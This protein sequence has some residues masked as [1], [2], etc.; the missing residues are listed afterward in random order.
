MDGRQP[1]VLLGVL[2]LA[3]SVGLGP[4]AA[5]GEEPD[6][7]RDGDTVE[8]DDDDSAENG[9]EIPEFD[10]EEVLVVTATRTERDVLDISQPVAVVNTSAIRETMAIGISDVIHKVPGVSTTNLGGV[11]YW[12]PVIRGLSG[13]RVVMLLD[14]TR[15][16]T[17]RTMGVTGFF[18]D[19][20]QVKRVEVVRG[21]SSVL[22]GTDAIGGVINVLTVDPFED[23]GLHGRLSTSVGHNN[24]EASGGLGVGYTSK[25]LTLGLNGRLRD[26]GNYVDGNGDEILMSHYSDRMFGGHLG[27]RPHED[28]RIMIRSQNVM[29]QDV[30]KAETE[31][32]REKHRWIHFPKDDIHRVSAAWDG[33]RLGR[34]VHAVHLSG[35]G[36]WNLRHNEINSFTSDYETLVMRMDKKTRVFDF[37]ANAHVVLDLHP[38]NRLTVG[39]EATHKTM[40]M[41]MQPIL[42]SPDGSSVEQDPDRQFDDATQATVGVFAQDEWRILRPLDLSL[43]LRFDHIRS[44]EGRIPDKPRIENNHALSGTLGMSVHTSAETRLT[45]NAGR[46]FRAPTL[47]ERFLTTTTCLGLM[48]GD[49]SLRPETSWNLDL[50]FKG[51]P[52]PVNFEVYAFSTWVQDLITARTG[53][54]TIDESCEFTYSNTARAW[55]VGGEGRFD[56]DIPVYREHVHLVPSVSASYVRGQDTLNDEPLPQSPPFSA[57]VALRL[58]GRHAPVLVK[59]FV[60]PKVTIFA[61]QDRPG[62]DEQASDAY[63]LVGLTAG[64]TFDGFL[65]FEAVHV[66]IRLENLVGTVY[67]AHLSATPGMGRNLKIGLTAEFGSEAGSSVEQRLLAPA[68]PGLRRAARLVQQLLLHKRVEQQLRRHAGRGG[69]RAGLVGRCLAPLEA[70][71]VG[72]GDAHLAQ[73]P[74]DHTLGIQQQ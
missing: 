33:E 14:G 36:Q 27:F 66:N 70:P 5:R 11:Y 44:D 53:L 72:I 29:L 32:D 8:G 55:L 39:V 12:N 74:L 48:C 51:R 35:H 69:H 28:H 67:Q 1:L 56:V 26:A 13:R 9:E 38:A 22:Y 15:L 30:G 42:F 47:A 45:L 63:A 17:V 41:W 31:Q 68:D 40:T 52:G 10:E 4:M 3:L 19:T 61:P 7:R 34:V 46:A 57:K 6:G 65:F 71:G 18:I 20:L 54:D 50:G 49:P 2:V 25:W 23:P 37:G 62:P 43:G 64:L 73:H 16:P 58:E 59:Y 60:T 24:R 21:P